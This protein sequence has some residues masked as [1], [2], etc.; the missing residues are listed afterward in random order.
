MA[1]NKPAEAENCDDGTMTGCAATC[2]AGDLI[3][4]QC[5]HAGSLA[6][7]ACIPVCEDDGT[8]YPVNLPFTCNDGNGN[9]AT[10]GC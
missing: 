4:W 7:S 6:G 3:G 2:K 9:G 5:T 10:D 1:I 8:S